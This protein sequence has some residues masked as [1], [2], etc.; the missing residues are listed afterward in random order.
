MSVG[1]IITQDEKYSTD[2]SPSWNG[3]NHQGKIGIFVV[4]KMI[5]DLNLSFDVCN[6]YE[7]ELEWLEDFSI[8]KDN[9]YISIHQ[10]KTY[11]KTAPSDYKDA[12]WLLL[13]KVTDFPNVEKAYLHSTRKISKLD[14]LE[15][16]L[17]DY[18]PPKEVK[19]KSKKNEKVNEIEENKKYWTP[20]QCHDYVKYTGE[21]H[22]VFKKFEMYTYESGCQHCSID[23]V[24]NKIKNQLSIFYKGNIKTSEQLNRAFLHL[25]GLVDKHIR[26]RHIDIQA[27][28]K[29]VKAT[30]NFQ[31]IY[32]LIA[33]NY[34]LPSKE[35]I[36][37]QLRDKFAK[38][39]NEYFSDLLLDL[40]DEIIKPND[41]INV[42]S[43]I[44]SVLELDE[45]KFIK[46]CMKITPNH[47]VNDENPD[48]ILYALSTLISETHMNDG[49]LE[50][51]KRIQKQIN[52]DKYTFIKL[53]QEKLNTTYLP[54]TIIDTYHMHR[55]G[56]MVEKILNNSHDESLLEVD[57]MITK[58][59]NLASLK[60]EKINSDIPEPEINN[61]GI[62]S[63][64]YHD[65]ISKIKKIRMVDL[66]K[67]K[68]EID[69]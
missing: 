60:P 57:V 68:G 22:R 52:V 10:V 44:N 63:E 41:I 35:Y 39:T 56:R 38:L 49:Y 51:L 43:V 36:I 2:A 7:I 40:K 1:K 47:E 8:K 50:I 26:E 18:K 32:E 27:G 30:I 5:N 45:E 19:K 9:D 59:I 37:Y 67:A 11:N 20:R 12:I 31:K 34:E 46:F 53:G 64:K 65:R 24:E 48:S 4:L 13:A 25:L 28:N 6:S 14:D 21:Y 66:E 54:T 62:H 17:Y 61:D 33:A 23:E 58:H 3:F 16:L 42:H 15:K 55:T 29:N 69:E